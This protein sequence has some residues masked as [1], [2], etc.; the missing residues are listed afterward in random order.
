MRTILA[1]GAG[2]NER[3]DVHTKEGDKENHEV[4]GRKVRAGERVLA[5]FQE[6]LCRMNAV[7]IICVH[8]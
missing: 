2:R 6:S 1:V 7:M 4:T 8:G 3:K 5:L